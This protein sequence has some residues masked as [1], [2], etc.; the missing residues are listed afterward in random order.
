ML[1]FHQSLINNALNKV[2]ERLHYPLAV[3]LTCV[4]WYGAYPLSLR[5][6][7]EMMKWTPLSRQS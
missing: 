5:H 2:L 7:E 1:D 6:V 4:R 3:M